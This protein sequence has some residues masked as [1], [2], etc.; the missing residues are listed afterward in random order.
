MKKMKVDPR[1]TMNIHE[2]KPFSS[3]NLF[4][5]FAS[6]SSFSVNSIG[7]SHSSV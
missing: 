2:L 7:L 3:K 4:S 5:G 6:Y 1:L